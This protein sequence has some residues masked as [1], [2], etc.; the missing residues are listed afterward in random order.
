MS[1]PEKIEPGDIVRDSEGVKYEVIRVAAVLIVRP[2][3]VEEVKALGVRLFEKRKKHI[4]QPF[5]EWLKE[6]DRKGDG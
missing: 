5:D 6:Q 2:Y 1:N 3:Y 4:V